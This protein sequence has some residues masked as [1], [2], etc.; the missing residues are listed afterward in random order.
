MHTT[1]K[2][3]P[4]L[5]VLDVLA[6]RRVATT[7]V[8]RTGPLGAGHNRNRSCLNILEGDVLFFIAFSHFSHVSGTNA[9]LK[10]LET[11][12]GQG[13][14]GGTREA[15]DELA[16]SLV[17]VHSRTRSHK[18]I[19][20][21]FHRD[22]LVDFLLSVESDAL[23]CHSGLLDERADGV[24]LVGNRAVIA[25]NRDELGHVHTGDPANFFTRC[26]A[27]V[28]GQQFVRRIVSERR[29]ND[30]LHGLRQV[31]LGHLRHVGRQVLEEFIVGTRIP[32]RVD[33]SIKGVHVGVHIRAGEV[34]LLV[35]GGRGKNDIRVQGGRGVA[36]VR[37]DH[38][39]EL[40]IGRGVTP[41]H[42]LGTISSF[43]FGGLNIIICAQ[44]VAHEELSTL[45]GG[46]QQVRTPVE[47][48]TREV[49]R[50]IG[51]F[52]RELQGAFGE[53]TR[54]VLANTDARFFGCAS[55]FQGGA[56][57]R[58]EGGHPATLGSLDQ[59][60]GNRLV[61]ESLAAQRRGQALSAQTVVTPLVGGEVP[62]TGRDHLACGTLPVKGEGE[63]G[64]TGQRTNLFL[65]DVVCPS[66][67]V[68]TLSSTE[69]GQSQHRAVDLVSV[70][71]VVDTRT[72]DDLRATV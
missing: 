30:V 37:G 31:N 23:R 43:Q 59:G 68:N 39:V 27:T 56:V 15:K 42:R 70:V 57:E 47:E 14:I 49:H 26:N 53:L 1:G 10:G 28:G 12:G 8:F 22:E 20:R 32:R 67:T 69:G 17:G 66:T 13:A 40:A 2:R 52:A 46:T 16:C 60:V 25:K 38:E 50:V 41:H 19:Q 64:P 34:V 33:R 3:V 54:D 24:V 36:E 7:T 9:L 58:G 18:G 21:S 29:C 55:Q 72:E 44:H 51:I 6:K 5:V 62:E 61:T 4:R 11:T 35:P 48:D 63:L 71:V 45:S 65:A